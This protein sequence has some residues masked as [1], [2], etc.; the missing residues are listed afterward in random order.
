MNQLPPILHVAMVAIDEPSAQR[1]CVNDNPPDFGV[2]SLFRDPKKLDADLATLETTL[3][4]K[5]LGYQIFQA[6]IGIRGAK[7]SQ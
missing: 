1:I 7:W 5:N 4:A 3:K 6:D 2:Q